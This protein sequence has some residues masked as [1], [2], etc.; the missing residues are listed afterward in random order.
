MIALLLCSG[1]YMVHL[2][3]VDSGVCH[4]RACACECLWVSCFINCILPA[5]MSKSQDTHVPC[6][7]SSSST[8]IL[9]ASGELLTC[10]H[11]SGVA[12][13]DAGSTSA[14]WSLN[15]GNVQWG[16]LPKKSP[17]PKRPKGSKPHQKQKKKSPYGLLGACGEFRS[18]YG[19]AVDCLWC[20]W[21]CGTRTFQSI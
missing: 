1:W 9:Y 16:S 11:K 12:W 10:G 8:G 14:P 13:G 15:L 19:G 2:N 21:L 5:P 18:R 6:V 7:R 4:D 20:A 3:W 17:H